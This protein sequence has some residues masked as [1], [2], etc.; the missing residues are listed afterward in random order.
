MTD[1]PDPDPDDGPDDGDEVGAES[2][3]GTDEAE[4]PGTGGAEESPGDAGTGSDAPLSDVAD[5]TGEDPAGPG[6]G[7]DRTGEAG[8]DP[9]SAAGSEAPADAGER[10]LSSS[11]ADEGQPE[12]PPGEDE[13]R[14]GPL[15]EIA[16]AVDRR[17]SGD[18]GD[19]DLEDLFTEESVGDV[20]SEAL[21]DRLEDDS[22]AGDA[23]PGRRDVRVVSKR[24]YCQGCP[25]FSEPPAVRCAHEGTE[26]LEL[27]DVDHVRVVDCP[28]VREDERLGGVRE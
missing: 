18:P 27:V 23:D 4:E 1:E 12:L 20:D 17:R 25:H 13:D 3:S 26:I 14:A 8:G 6:D 21:W 10:A 7:G 9:G 28:V 22:F 2:E 19:R 5:R 11:R 24:A 16:T 15:A